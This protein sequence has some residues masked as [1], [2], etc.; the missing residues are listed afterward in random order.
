[1]KGSAY[2]NLP[3]TEMVVKDVFAY[4]VYRDSFKAVSTI[5]NATVDGANKTGVFVPE[6]LPAGVVQAPPGRIPKPNGG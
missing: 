1:M 6:A 5:Y 4:C 2:H 3:E